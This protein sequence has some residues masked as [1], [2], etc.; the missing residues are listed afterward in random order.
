MN[1]DGVRAWASALDLLA[2]ARQQS[3]LRRVHRIV[4]AKFRGRLIEMVRERT[5]VRLRFP[6]TPAWSSDQPPYAGDDVV[7]TPI[8]G[9][10]H[11]ALDIFGFVRGQFGLGESVRNYSRALIGAG[12]QVALHDVDLG[13]R[14]GW[15]DHSLDAYMNA[16]T[17]YPVS[18]IFINPDVFAQALDQ[19]GHQQLVGKRVIGC[20]FW[21]LERVPDSWLAALDQVDAVMVA[22]SFIAEAFARTTDKPL[23]RVPLPLAAVRDSGLQR[24]DFGLDEHSFVFLTSFDFNSHI[25]RKNPLAVVTAFKKA[26]P[27]ERADV[28]LVVKSSNGHLHEGELRSLLAAAAGDSRIVLRDEV[29]DRAHVRALQR[30]CDAYVSLHRAEGFGLGLAECM[31]LGKPVI[32]TGWSGNMEFMNEDNSCLVDY[33]LVPVGSCEYPDSTGA[34]WAEADIDSAAN[35][36][37][38]LVDSPGLAYRIGQRAQRDVRE[39]LSPTAAAKSLLEELGRLGYVSNEEATSC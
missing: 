19:I 28:G 22:S 5:R 32:A 25:A 13:L 9:A 12:Y 14:H 17:Q 15:G 18:I 11:V 36:M 27:Q 31:E 21:E 23:L 39:R 24:S 3:W 37:I 10:E 8:V 29:I 20:W 26:F 2:W 1:I 4:P 33:T 35:A 34:V 7:A 30:C 16:D 6:R 38:R